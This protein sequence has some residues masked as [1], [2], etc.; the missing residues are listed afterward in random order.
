MRISIWTSTSPSLILLCEGRC[1]RRWSSG[2]RPVAPH[3]YRIAVVGCFSLPLCRSGPGPNYQNH[4]GRSVNYVKARPPISAAITQP[5]SRMVTSVGRSRRCAALAQFS[6]GLM[7][8]N[9]KG[10]TTKNSDATRQL[11]SARRQSGDADAQVNLGGMYAKG[12]QLSA[13]FSHCLPSG[14]R[15][16]AKLSIMGRSVSSVKA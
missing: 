9:G 1:Q 11:G 7:Y 13:A 15:R 14:L 8:A 6:L 12:K 4:V 10:V 16:P 3:W 5:S 2:P